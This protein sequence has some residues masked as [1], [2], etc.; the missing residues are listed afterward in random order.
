MKVR[1]FGKN[2]DLKPF[3]SVNIDLA[4]EWYYAPE[5]YVGGTYF[6]KDLSDWITTKT[7]DVTL[8]DPIQGVDRVFQKT[9]PFNAESAKVSGLELAL[10]HN[11]DSGFGIQAN[12]TMLDTTGAADT[13]S[14]SRVN[15]HGL[16]DS[17]YNVIGFYENGPIQVRIAYNWREGYTTCN[18]CIDTKGVNGA[19]SIDDY[20][21]IDASASYDVTDEISIFVDVINLTSE[22]PY[23]YTIRKSN[24]L[25]IADTGTRY[26]VGVRAN[27]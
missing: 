6:R 24:V 18:Y 15:L 1:L 19:K 13:T 14:E 17:S 4:L 2:S 26:S 10:L 11:F 22:D 20:G 21:Q 16:S 5:S 7:Q 12:Y 23:E 9:L 25:S 3:T 8:H 27:F